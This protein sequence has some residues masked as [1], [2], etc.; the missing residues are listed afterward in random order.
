MWNVDRL[1][2]Q[3]PSKEEDMMEQHIQRRKSAGMESDT[4]KKAA[5]SRAPILPQNASV[6]MTNM[7]MKQE[8]TW[9]TG[10]IWFVKH[11]VYKLR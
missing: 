4:R 1:W 3:F 7:N 9:A 8:N 2:V 5:T 11:I 10:L 6:T